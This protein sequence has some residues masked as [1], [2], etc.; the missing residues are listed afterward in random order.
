MIIRLLKA[1]LSLLCL[2]TI[3]GINFQT[4]QA[5]DSIV[6][7]FFADPSQSPHHKWAE[8]V[9]TEAFNRLGYKFEYVVY[10]P[11]RSSMEVGFGRIDGEVARI[12]S[13]G[14]NHLNIIKVEES[15]LSEQ[16]LAIV[17]N[18]SIQIENWESL[19][20]AAYRVEYFRGIAIAEQKLTD[21]IENK[22]LTTISH[23]K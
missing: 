3:I 19:R 2:F 5:K 11:K 21:L 7:S 17:T 1:M 13:Y 16:V 10:P 18:E 6:F 23:P 20:D 12:S 9:Y 22:Y 14:K 15:V 4:V 8:L